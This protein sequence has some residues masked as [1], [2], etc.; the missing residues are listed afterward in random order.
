MELKA[1]GFGRIT[2][3]EK[4]MD[5]NFNL[6]FEGVDCVGKSTLIKA[7]NQNK[8]FK[9]RKTER[10][11]DR[12]SSIKIYNQ[13]S[14]E[15]TQ[16]GVIGDRGLICDRGFISELVYS[17]LYR[18]YNS[19]YI[20]DLI[21][22]AN[23]VIYVF[24]DSN[25]EKIKERFDFDY[26]KLKDIEYLQKRFHEEFINIPH[27]YIDTSTSTVKEEVAELEK[28]LGEKYGIN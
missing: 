28:L 21:R 4:E 19:D 1:L 16:T 25:I 3:K 2:F 8:N 12:N 13:L 26:V 6:M 24:V 9:L 5:T 23:N 22:K 11:N 10:P 15:L 18:N 14:L 27:I 7:F 20:Y 17:P